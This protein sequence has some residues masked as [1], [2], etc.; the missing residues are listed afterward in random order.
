VGCGDEGV[1]CSLPELSMTPA[2]EIWIGTTALASAGWIEDGATVAA[3]MADSNL[4]HNTATART[5][6]VAPRRLY[7]S[8]V[9]R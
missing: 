3:G 1:A 8:C 9:L 7:L 5:E 2:P 4:G 6:L